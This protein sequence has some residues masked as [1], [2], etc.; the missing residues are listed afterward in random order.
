MEHQL[1]KN[2][3]YSSHGKYGL[4]VL[5]LAKTDC[6]SKLCAKRMQY[7]DSNSATNTNWHADFSKKH[8]PWADKHTVTLLKTGN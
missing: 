3:D 5:Q 4:S 7:R 8:D 2:K 1:K 6:S